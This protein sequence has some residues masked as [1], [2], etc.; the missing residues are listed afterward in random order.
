MERKHV[1]RNGV[2][3]YEYKNPATHGFFIS[4]FL[5]AG[6]MFEED[7]ESGITH[8]LEHTLIRNVN[9]VMD[10]RLYSELDSHGVE[11]NAST[12]SEMVQFFVSG[13][14]ANFSFGAEVI[15]RLLSP[16]A[17]TRGEI[18][19]ERRRIK[20]E[21]R[22]GDDRT[23]LASFSNGVVHEGTALAKPITGTLGSVGK[24]TLS[25][26]EEYRRRV[27]VSDNFFF[28]VTG[29][30][31]DEDI[32]KLVSLIES[33]EVRYGKSNRNIAPVSKNFLS[34]SGDV[35]VK[36]ADYTMLRFN[37][38][39]NMP[40]L[41][42][43]KTDLLYDMLLSGYNSR[44]F[45]EMSEERGLLYDLNGALERYCNAGQ[46]YFSFEVKERDIYDALKLTVSILKEIK[47]TLPD[48]K[49]CMK[50]GYVDNAYMLYDDQRDLNFTF[51]YDNHIMGLGYAS[52][53]ER[54]S[55]Y[56]SVTP[57]DIKSTACEIFSI[58]NLT[59]TVKGNKKR[60][61]TARLKDIIN[62]L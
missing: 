38:D 16:I 50:A 39:L 27:F 62:G 25:A 2:S 36:N 44:L 40:K 22:E 19:A 48:E 28:Y 33:C 7:G 11:F 13:G 55:A 43:P 10:F 4:L 54:R 15:S 34:R 42:V 47:Q 21:I 53:E 20:A 60:I 3:V 35:F 46:L 52:V 9:K 30:F 18:D 57:F 45:I 23:S 51:A 6:S 32:E 14:S 26:L 58:N 24:I 56:A 61:D 17:L 49:D 41:S 1:T 59:L 5:K 8:F 12:Y 37:F 29:N 31:T